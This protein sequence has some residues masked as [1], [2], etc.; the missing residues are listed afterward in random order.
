M[1]PLKLGELTDYRV[2][3][4]ADMD[5]HVWERWVGYTWVRGDQIYGYKESL[6]LYE[7]IEE[8][9]GRTFW[10]RK[11]GPIQEPPPPPPPE[12]PSLFAK[13]AL[14][15]DELLDPT[16]FDP[17]YYEP[18]LDRMVASGE[19]TADAPS[20]VPARPTRPSPIRGELR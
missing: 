2:P 4:D 11:Y 1:T 12:P 9:G 5:V 20:C 16:L 13:R 18:I 19:L 8:F 6:E 15:M 17:Q 3:Y 14:T 7:C 10:V